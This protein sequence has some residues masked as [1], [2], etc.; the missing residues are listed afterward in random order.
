V[1]DEADRMLDMG[2]LPDVSAI[3]E[4]IPSERQTL[5]FSATVPPEIERLVRRFMREPVRIQIDPPRKPAAGITQKV[6]PVTQSQKYG[7]LKALIDHFQMRSVL[8]F[9][10]TK[11]RADIVSGF[12][13]T[14]GVSAQAMHSDLPQGKRTQ[15]MDAFR[16]QKHRVLVATDIAA[17][18]LDIRHVSHVINFDVPLYAEDYLHR[19]GRTAR[20]FTVGDALTLMAPAEKGPVV[21]I[22]AFTGTPIERCLLESFKYDVPPQLE[23]FR[24]SMSSRFRAGRRTFKRGKRGLM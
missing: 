19:I 23:V 21:S 1:L 17:R 14:Q 10:A 12:L 7:L 16:E 24:P 4:R 9:T 3:L 13:R 18:G 8:V 15:V 5:M 20:V 11:K 22:E 2:F 6:Y